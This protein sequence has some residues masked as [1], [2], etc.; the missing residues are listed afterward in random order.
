MAGGLDGVAPGVGNAH[1]GA[2]REAVRG[3]AFGLQAP[4]GARRG[5]R[6]REDAEEQLAHK[7]DSLARSGRRRITPYGRL[8]AAGQEPVPARA[9]DGVGASADIELSVDRPHMG[10]DR[11]PRDVKRL[12]D[13]GQGQV[14]RQQLQ[15]PELGGGERLAEHAAAAARPPR[16]PAPPGRAAAGER[17]RPGSRR[18]PA[19][20]PPATLPPAGGRRWRGRPGRAARASG[21]TAR[22]PRRPGEGPTRAF[23]RWTRARAEVAASG[24]EARG[25]G[26][27][28]GAGGVVSQAQLGDEREPL[29]G[30]SPPP[31]RAAPRPGRS[32]P[33]R[34][35]RGSRPAALAAPSAEASSRRG[36]ASAVRPSSIRLQPRAT[37]A[38]SCAGCPAGRRR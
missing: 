21:S 30:P 25:G 4:Q 2:R 5:L 15:H 1:G 17:R 8:A 19:A 6:S 34:P 28:G 11:V 31:R 37:A 38:G 20:P 35:G 13:H 3:Q 10:L 29:L 12:A 22:A 9:R 18:A 16:A 33:A 32:A 7:G 27:D 26:V 14:R 36:T 23:S 24:A